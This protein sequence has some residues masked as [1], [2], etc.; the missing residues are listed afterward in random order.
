MVFSSGQYE[1]RRGDKGICQSYIKM[2]GARGS[3]ADVNAS[4]GIQDL[5]RAQL[6][7]GQAQS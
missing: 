4:K 7:I 6:K 1:T 3:C 5:L 2:R